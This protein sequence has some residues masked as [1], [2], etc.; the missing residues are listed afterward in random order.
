LLDVA[1]GLPDSLR[2]AIAHG[3]AT[4]DLSSAAPAADAYRARHAAKARDL[5]FHLAKRARNLH[6]VVGVRLHSPTPLGDASGSQPWRGNR[7]LIWAAVV[8][9]SALVR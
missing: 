2:R 5:S 6:K 3:I 9:V 1:D 8:V 7:A 4:D